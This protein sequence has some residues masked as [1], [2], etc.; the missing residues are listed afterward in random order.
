[1]NE[2]IKCNK[3]AVYF[4]LILGIIFVVQYK[5]LNCAVYKTISTGHTTSTDC[6]TNHRVIL[7][8]MLFITFWCKL[9]KRG[10]SRETCTYST[11]VNF[12]WS[13]IHPDKLTCVCYCWTWKCLILTEVSLRNRKA[14]FLITCLAAPNPTFTLNGTIN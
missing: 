1:M 11:W 5:Y 3:L 8:I 2:I 14:C 10:S 4:E 6:N 12:F 9:L 13:N 7:L